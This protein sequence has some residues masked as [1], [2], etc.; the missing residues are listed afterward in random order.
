MRAEALHADGNLRVLADVHHQADRRR[1]PLAEDGRIGRARNTHLREAEQAED[2]NRVKNDVDD[3]ARALADHRQQRAAGALQ[4]ALKEDLHENAHRADHDDGRIV[5][6]ALHD[7]LDVRLHLKIRAHNRHAAEHED[8]AADEQQH[9][10]VG[11]RAVHAFLVLRAQRAR[12]HR[13]QAHAQTRRNRD[14]QVLNREGHAQRRQRVFAHARHKHGIHHVVERLHQHGNHNRQAHGKEQLAHGHHAHFILLHGRF[15]FH[16]VFSR[17]RHDVPHSLILFHSLQFHIAQDYIL[18]VYN[19]SV[20]PFPC[21]KRRFSSKGKA[22]LFWY[23]LNRTSNTAASRTDPDR[24]AAN[25][26]SSC[27]SSG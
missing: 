19:H 11:R 21:K 20:N 1:D 7:F 6:A 5:D 15:V 27:G 10:A 9:D 12:E 8:Q 2:E 13:V 14:H 18:T 25:H 17:V 24:R 16:I 3:C 26:S 22:A 23:I 4:Q